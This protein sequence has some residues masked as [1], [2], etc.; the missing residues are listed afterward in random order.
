MQRVIVGAEDDSR[1]MVQPDPVLPRFSHYIMSGNPRGIPGVRHF[2]V[3]AGK[4][5]ERRSQ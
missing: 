3:I 4:E 1:F 5:S 2:K